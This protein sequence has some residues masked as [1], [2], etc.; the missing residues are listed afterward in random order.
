LSVEYC[1]SKIVVARSTALSGCYLISRSINALA[2]TPQIPSHRCEAVAAAE[3]NHDTS[4]RAFKIRA[5]PCSTIL[6]PVASCPHASAQIVQ[7]R[8]HQLRRLSA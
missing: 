3:S 7:P 6:A 1:P 5:G 2:T 8:L 4:R